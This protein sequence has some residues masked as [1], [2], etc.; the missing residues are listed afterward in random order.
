MK[1]SRFHQNVS[2][3]QN[4]R[5]HILEEHVLIF[6]A[7]IS[8]KFLSFP[9][10]PLHCFLHQVMSL[11][12]DSLHTVAARYVN[13]SKASVCGHSSAQIVGSNPTGGMDVL[14]AVSV[15]CCHVEVPATG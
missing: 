1:I 7:V 3:C 4:I 12:V 14:S 10:F 6:T 5:R 2:I 15:G 9:F 13:R 8:S 11:S